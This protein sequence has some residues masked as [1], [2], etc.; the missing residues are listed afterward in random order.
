MLELL[1]ACA[2]SLVATPPP[3]ADSTTSEHIA[4]A[5]NHWGQ[6]R[7]LTDDSIA[8]PATYAQSEKKHSSW[9]SSRFY[10][11]SALPIFGRPSLTRV[12]LRHYLTTVRAELLPHRIDLSILCAGSEGN[13]SREIALSEGADY[14]EVAN[15]PVSNKRNQALRAVH[16][17]YHQVDAVII[18]DSDDIA[19]A[20]YFI[21]AVTLLRSQPHV[22]T[23]SVDALHSLDV[24][25]G[26][27]LYSGGY[28][29]E[30]RQKMAMALALVLRAEV[31][32]RVQWSPWKSGLNRSLDADLWPTLGLAYGYDGRDNMTIRLC[33]GSLG[34]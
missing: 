14:I 7:R 24:V 2:W 16:E 4:G 3:M 6:P 18:S 21:Q 32:D 13:A 29:P 11:V 1:L 9:S 8:A 22:S 10:L 28:P 34:C 26:L 19:S 25:S 5:H 31:M 27:G 33:Q 23:V 15:F 12:V 30:A 17:R 20:D